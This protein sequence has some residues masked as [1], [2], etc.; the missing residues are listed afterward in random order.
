MRLLVV[1]QAVDRHDPVLG[2]FH[3]W[4]AAFGRKTS[5]VEAIAQRVGAHLLPADSVR[6][7]SLH[8]EHGRT[9][10]FQVVRFWI[11][12]W[13][14]R[15]RYDAVFVHM[16]PVW[17]VLGGPLWMLLGKPVYLWY[18]ARGGGWAL[19]VGMWFA[20][21]VFS[22]SARGMPMKTGKS[23][24]VGHGIDTQL[25]APDGRVRD[26]EVVLTVGRV[27]RSK[28]LPLI[29]SC[30][31]ALPPRT[32]LRVVGGPITEDDHRLLDELKADLEKRNLLARVEFGPLP[33]TG[34]VPLLRGAGLFLHASETAL[35]KALLEAMACGCPVLS[36]AAVAQGFLPEACVATPET[37]T[38][39]AQALLVL[40]AP[41]REALGEQL[42]VVVARDHGLPRLVDR[43]LAEMGDRG[44]SA[45]AS[46]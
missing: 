4:L 2:F 8:K 10:A 28:R 27:T 9:R 45:A 44:A 13:R 7:H 6:V 38:A 30:F 29:I 26:P 35:D 24:I 42:H 33:Q 23:V 17:A 22:A 36:C 40:S 25:F 32:L 16:T 15:A 11:L 41:E 1:T 19:R 3:D 37:F 18:E 5:G 39:R 14:L 31:A 43:L 20:R 34:L 12:A 46:R 21:K